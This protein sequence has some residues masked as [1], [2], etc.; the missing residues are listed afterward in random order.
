MLTSYNNNNNL[1]AWHGDQ[2]NNGKVNLSRDNFARGINN[3]M[4]ASLK[5]CLDVFFCN[6][7]EI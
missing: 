5:T 7:N 4:G 2:T 1:A 3:S 6:Y